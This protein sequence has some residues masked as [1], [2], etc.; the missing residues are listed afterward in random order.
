MYRFWVCQE[1]QFPDE[2]TQKKK[3]RRASSLIIAS[4]YVGI[5]QIRLWVE[6]ELRFLSAGFHQLP[7]CNF[8][9]VHEMICIAWNVPI[10]QLL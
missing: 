4:R 1:M 6:A 10:Y 7:V 9:N 3:V 5:I 2:I 8:R